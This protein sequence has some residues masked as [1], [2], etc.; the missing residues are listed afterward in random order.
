MNFKI[1]ICFGVFC[2]FMVQLPA[3]EAQIEGLQLAAML[4]ILFS[5]ERL[6]G[7]NRA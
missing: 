4:L 1:L 2:V 6:E 5:L 3:S 7:R